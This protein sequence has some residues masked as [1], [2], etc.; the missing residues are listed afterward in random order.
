VLFE[1]KIPAWR[2]GTAE[3]EDDITII[4]DDES[5]VR[6]EDEKREEDEK[7]NVV[8]HQGATTIS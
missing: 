4:G 5:Q 1:K 2:F 3:V 7:R 6:V 8:E